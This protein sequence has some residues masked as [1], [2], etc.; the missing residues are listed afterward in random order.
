MR[1]PSGTCSEPRPRRGGGVGRPRTAG[2]VVAAISLRYQHPRRPGAARLPGAVLRANGGR[3]RTQ[4]HDRR[5]AFAAFH[6]STPPPPPPP[7]PRPA[8][9]ALFPVPRRR[10]CPVGMGNIYPEPLSAAGWPRHTWLYSL[11]RVGEPTNHPASWGETEA[12]GGRGGLTQ[13]HAPR[14]HM[15]GLAPTSG[16]AAVPQGHP[17]PRS[18]LCACLRRMP[19]GPPTPCVS[20]A[21]SLGQ[22]P[23]LPGPGCLRSVLG[24]QRPQCG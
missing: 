19:P 13:G 2:H 18:P 15:S 22:P 9:P 3:D 12:Q 1:R 23:P 20:A 8:S 21:A 24:C 14:G 6:S 10:D 17:V 7:P 16:N 4:A 5:P 11:S